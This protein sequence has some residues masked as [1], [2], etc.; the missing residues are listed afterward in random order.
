[1]QQV[2]ELQE[3][4]TVL[5]QINIF[6]NGVHELQPLQNVWLYITHLYPEQYH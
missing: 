1:M 2:K 6:L 4:P 5:G 3:K